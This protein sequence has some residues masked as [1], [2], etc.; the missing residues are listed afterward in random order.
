[1]TNI[2]GTKNAFIEMLKMENVHK[3]LGLS[4]PTVSN[5]R[6][7]LN[8]KGNMMPTIDKMEEMLIKYGA[9]VATDKSW[10]LPTMCITLLINIY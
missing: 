8:G 4:A 9:E 10:L 1:M 3:V 7:A 6:R 5:W 2:T